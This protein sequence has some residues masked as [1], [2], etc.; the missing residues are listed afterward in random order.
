MIGYSDLLYVKKNGGVHT[1]LKSDQ[2][3]KGNGKI[4]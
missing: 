1:K 2:C 4:E 3:K